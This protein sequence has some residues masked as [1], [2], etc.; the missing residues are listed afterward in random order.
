MCI[1]ISGYV[2]KR[3]ALTSAMRRSQSGHGETCSGY[4]SPVLSV[5]RIVDSDSACN[6]GSS[7]PPESMDE[8]TWLIATYRGLLKITKLLRDLVLLVSMH[9]D[10]P[11]GSAK[12]TYCEHLVHFIKALSHNCRN[13]LSASSCL[14]VRPHGTT[15]FPPDGLAWNL[16]FDF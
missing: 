12:A 7:R 5:S 10:G 2:I 8:M 11:D 16:I 3:A 4:R 1:L 6:S 9:E 14:S 13:R 15:R